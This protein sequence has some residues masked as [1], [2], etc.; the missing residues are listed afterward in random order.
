MNAFLSFCIIFA[1]WCGTYIL[2]RE[3]REL[4]VTDR[5]FSFIQHSCNK[6][7]GEFYVEKSTEV[8]LT[9]K[10]KDIQELIGLLTATCKTANQNK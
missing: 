4:R 6:T 5:G 9:I 3:Q 2:S 1:C 10:R 8:P 7:V